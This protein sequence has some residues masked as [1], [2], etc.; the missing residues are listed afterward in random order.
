MDQL[1]LEYLLEQT[2]IIRRQ[3]L[4]PSLVRSYQS[5]FSVIFE[6]MDAPGRVFI[7]EGTIFC[8]QLERLEEAGELEGFS[9]EAV[10]AL[11]QLQ[12]R[13][14][15]FKARVGLGNVGGDRHEVHTLIKAALER[16]KDYP[17]NGSRLIVQTLQDNWEIGL[18]WAAF[19]CLEG[20][21]SRPH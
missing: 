6:D 8:R 12:K 13:G 15:I 14:P 21:F 18:M 19:S 17:A 16:L 2:A 3:R 20:D 4:C 11:T 10:A 7:Q 9:L 5:P 1:D